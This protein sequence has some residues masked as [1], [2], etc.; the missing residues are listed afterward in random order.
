M[1]C[2]TFTFVSTLTLTFVLSLTLTFVST[3]TLTPSGH[4]KNC[5]SITIII[6][7]FFNTSSYL[8]QFF[9]RLTFRCRTSSCSKFLVLNFPRAHRSRADHSRA[10]R[11]CAHRSVL[12]VPCS[13]FLVLIVPVPVVVM[14][15][16][17]LLY[18]E[19]S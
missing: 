9:S 17:G 13:S 2:L 5:I 11:F 8:V 10:Y 14:S 19:Y 18:G 15:P 12:I 1:L 6:Y 16:Q 3:L 7:K 4:N